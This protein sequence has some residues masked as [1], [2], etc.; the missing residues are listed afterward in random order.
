[1]KVHCDSCAELIADPEVNFEDG[2]VL[3]CQECAQIGRIN[4]DCTD[5]GVG[6]VEFLIV[7]DKGLSH[8]DFGTLVD[9]YEA[10]QKKL[11][12][13]WNQV[14]TLSDKQIE[15]KNLLKQAFMA[16]GENGYRGDL[17]RQIQDAVK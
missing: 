13:T 17:L 9:G 5:D 11:D 10:S 15:L 6:Y 3:V 14:A 12:E 16:L 8:V 2:Q 7:S 1:M 4:I